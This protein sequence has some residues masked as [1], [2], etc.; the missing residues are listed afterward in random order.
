VRQTADVEMKK[1]TNSFDSWYFVFPSIV[2]GCHTE[3]C[4]GYNNLRDK[5]GALIHY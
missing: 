3:N 2:P 1:R 4:T 5:P